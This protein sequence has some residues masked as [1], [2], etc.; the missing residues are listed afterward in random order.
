MVGAQFTDPPTV[1][2]CSWGN[3]PVSN[4]MSACEA[5]HCL[6]SKNEAEPVS[7]PSPRTEILGDNAAGSQLVGRTRRSI[8]CGTLPRNPNGPGHAFALRH[9]G[10]CSRAV[11]LSERW[12]HTAT[13]RN[14]NP[15]SAA[16]GEP[17]RASAT[18]HG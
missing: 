4:L 14:R 10:T 12:Q 1:G 17:F 11:G 15:G 16:H 2:S 9:S 3:R 8:G 5:P 6:R 18:V 7:V 13:Y